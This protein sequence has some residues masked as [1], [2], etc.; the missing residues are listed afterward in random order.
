MVSFMKAY[1]AV[2]LPIIVVIRVSGPRILTI[3][4]HLGYQ[5]PCNWVAEVRWQSFRVDYCFRV[6]PTT[7]LRCLT[8]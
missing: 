8:M 2:D 5:C 1:Y 4:L 3:G 7:Y 6:D